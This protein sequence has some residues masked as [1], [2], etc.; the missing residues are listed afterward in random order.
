M[1]LTLFLAVFVSG[2]AL[3]D[4]VTGKV[5]PND[6]NVQ[7]Q[8]EQVDSGVATVGTLI[9]ASG[10]PIVSTIGWFLARLKPAKVTLDL[11]TAIQNIRAKAKA[12]AI[13]KDE[14]D[15]LLKTLLSD[16][17]QSEVAKVK[18]ANPMATT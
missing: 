4:A 6:P 18:A 5:D 1:F 10:I 14:I 11:V 7:A 8:A 17:T 15:A 13:T 9:A 3:V 2:C 12:G 16:V